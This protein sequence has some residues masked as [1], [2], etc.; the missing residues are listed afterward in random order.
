MP[1]GTIKAM[2]HSAVT[3]ETCPGICFVQNALDKRPG[4]YQSMYL[5]FLSHGPGR[6]LVLHFGCGLSS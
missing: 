2:S 4:G 3:A 6:L 1:S 5:V